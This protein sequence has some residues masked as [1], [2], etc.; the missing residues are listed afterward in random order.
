[1]ALLRFFVGWLANI[2]VSSLKPAGWLSKMQNESTTEFL[3]VLDELYSQSLISTDE[4]CTVQTHQVFT[5]AKIGNPLR[6]SF[7]A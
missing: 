1:M 7:F 6:R 5:I 2:I 4:K 3:I